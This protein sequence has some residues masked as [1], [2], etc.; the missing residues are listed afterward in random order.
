MTLKTT[1]SPLITFSK[2]LEFKYHKLGDYW[3][4]VVESQKTKEIRNKYFRL[5]NQYR[6]ENKYI[7]YMDETYLTL[8]QRDNGKHC[9]QLEKNSDLKSKETAQRLII[10]HGGGINGFIK[11]A[12]LIFQ[13][14]V[15]PDT[16]H[17]GMNYDIFSTWMIENYLPNLPKNSVII[18]DN[19]PYHNTQVLRAPDLNSRRR[20]IM[21]WLDDK[22]VPYRKNMLKS[23]LYAKV[24]QVKNDKQKYRI[25]EI[26]ESAGHTVLR[27]PPY[28]TELNPIENVWTL[29]KGS[30]VNRYSKNK[31][32]NIVDI[33]I[34]EFSK[35]TA[36]D[37]QN[38]ISRVQIIEKFYS[39][40]DLYLN[41]IPNSLFDYCEEC[42]TPF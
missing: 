38:S 40:F 30:I 12:L 13:S 2:K 11:N 32:N 15:R 42:V 9:N 41:K 8:V 18:F 20:D 24:L 37:W 16:S 36:E 5:L 33:A 26:V 22:D 29:A 23:E 19:A 39:N 6:A 14:D 31:S 1:I 7:T 34:N 28:H 3:K 4:L 10:V 21:N 35:I 27:L 17:K 25:D